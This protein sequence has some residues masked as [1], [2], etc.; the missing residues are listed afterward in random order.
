[1]FKEVRLRAVTESIMQILSGGVIIHT[2]NV[3]VLADFD[4]TLIN[5]TL[6]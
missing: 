5:K 1:M 4:K 6:I 2:Y 3:C